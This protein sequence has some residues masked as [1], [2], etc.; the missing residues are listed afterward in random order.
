MHAKPRTR[1][2]ATTTIDPYGDFVTAVTE[3]IKQAMDNQGGMSEAE[4]RVVQAV[5]KT[6]AVHD[7]HIYRREEDDA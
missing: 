2:E 6:L 5:R 1:K 3:A 4:Y 7:P